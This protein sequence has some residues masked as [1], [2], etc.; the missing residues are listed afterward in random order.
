MNSDNAQRGKK[1][2]LAQIKCGH[3]GF[4]IKCGI[5]HI[6]QSLS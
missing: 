6:C 2:A 4:V 3:L 5:L 1:A